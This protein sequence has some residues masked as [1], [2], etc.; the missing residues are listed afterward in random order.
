MSVE[1]PLRRK[2]RVGGTGHYKSRTSNSSQARPKKH[3]VK[4][5]IQAAQEITKAH[6]MVMWLDF[7][8]GNG[9][10]RWVRQAEYDRLRS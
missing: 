3:A 5:E 1:I 7:S 2:Y 6:Q 8:T 4:G 10:I 9:K